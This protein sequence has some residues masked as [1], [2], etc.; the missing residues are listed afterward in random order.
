M[1]ISSNV[2]VCSTVC[3]STSQPA[4]HLPTTTQY[5]HCVVLDAVSVRLSLDTVGMWYAYGVPAGGGTACTMNDNI[6][7]W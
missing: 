3:F 4:Y 1:F 5:T 6:P 2:A 7:G